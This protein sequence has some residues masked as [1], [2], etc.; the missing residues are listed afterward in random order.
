ME[1]GSPLGEDVSQKPCLIGAICRAVCRNGAVPRIHWFVYTLE[2][3]LV[4]IIRARKLVIKV[5]E[6][7]RLSIKKNG[8]VKESGLLSRNSKKDYVW[9]K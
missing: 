7:S 1:Y 6:G 9:T 4:G 2:D 3:V 5:V 8:R